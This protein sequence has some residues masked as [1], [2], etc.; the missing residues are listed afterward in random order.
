MDKY[1][2]TRMGRITIPQSC[3]VKVWIGKYG[4]TSEE[5]LNKPINIPKPNKNENREQVRGDPY[6]SDIPEWLQEFR[7]KSCGRQS[8]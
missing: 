2:E 4:E 5:L 6:Y 7:E 1:G 8:S 3:Q